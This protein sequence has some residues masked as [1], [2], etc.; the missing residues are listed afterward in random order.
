MC[1]YLQ[2]HISAKSKSNICELV[3]PTILVFSIALKWKLFET[4]LIIMQ[5]N[6]YLFNTN[7]WFKVRS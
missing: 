6:G 2:K 5:Y 4:I 3:T 7:F 1:L